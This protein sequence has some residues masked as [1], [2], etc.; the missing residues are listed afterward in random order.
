MI[1][2]VPFR[3]VPRPSHANAQLFAG[4]RSSTNNPPL[5]HTTCT[6]LFRRPSQ[7][8]TRRTLT[9]AQIREWLAHNHAYTTPSDNH[10]G[11]C[12]E[13]V[14]PST[15]HTQTSPSIVPPCISSPCP[16]IIT[17]SF[18][19]VLRQSRSHARSD[20]QVLST[21]RQQSIR[22]QPGAELCGARFDSARSKGSVLAL[23]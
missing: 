13:Y 10:L 6:P 20:A 15:P 8:A 14:Y 18:L 12:V 7:P 17:H 2:R 19:A 5:S 11:P 16:A 1:V 4:I 23:D 21:C 22:E 3:P 9:L